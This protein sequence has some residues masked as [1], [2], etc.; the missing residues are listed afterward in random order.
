[1]KQVNTKAWRQALARA[2][3][4]DVRWHDSRHTSASWLVHAG[5]PLNVLQEMGGWES[6]S[7][8]RRYAHLAADQLAHYAER[9]A[10]PRMVQRAGTKLVQQL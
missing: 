3:I 7:M 2:G 10:R 8:V 6:V 1:M 4:E 9:L 5:T